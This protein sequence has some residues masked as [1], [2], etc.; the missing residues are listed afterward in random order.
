MEKLT[1]GEIMSKLD[2][3]KEYEDRQEFNSGGEKTVRRVF[4]SD[5]LLI[6]T[7]SAN[8]K[9][10]TALWE[11]YKILNASAGNLIKSFRLEGAVVI[12][13]HRY[14]S[15]TEETTYRL[16]LEELTRIATFLYKE[17]DDTGTIERYIKNYLNLCL[18][19]EK[20]R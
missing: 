10:I 5:N 13:C 18:M 16:L 15:S 14:K 4:Y 17:I 12:A 11:L 6:T 8:D 19:Y 1:V 2:P 9:V 3:L 7:Y 20:D